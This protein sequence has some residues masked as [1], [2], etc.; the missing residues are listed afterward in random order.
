LIDEFLEPCHS[1]TRE[2]SHKTKNR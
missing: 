1:P 2:T